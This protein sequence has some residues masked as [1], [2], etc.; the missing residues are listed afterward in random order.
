MRKEMKKKI[1]QKRKEKDLLQGSVERGQVLVEAAESCL[2]IRRQ[3]A[4]VFPT[5][6]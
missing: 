2:G 4:Q 3:V 5:P 6:K 1:A